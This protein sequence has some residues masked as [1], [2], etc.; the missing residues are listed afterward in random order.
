ME[1]NFCF[2]SVIKLLIA[3]AC[4]FLLGL[5]RKAHNHGLGILTLVLICVSSA[6]L[7]LLSS[8]MATKELFAP[9]GRG[10]PT[11][12][13]AGVISGIGFLGGG[14]IMKTGLNIRGLTSAAVIWT[15]ASLGL[16]VGAG[17]YIEVGVTLFLALLFLMSLEKLEYKWFPAAKSKTIHLCY[18]GDSINLKKIQETIEKHKL[19]IIDMNMSRVFSAKP[20]TFIHYTVKSPAGTIYTPLIDNLKN[21]G[22]LSE[23]SITD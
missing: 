14:A 12:I 23:F 13:A 20:L 18:E 3:V 22:T 15:S 19:I 1:I 10:D 7:S 16:A 21:L 2:E 5:E 6:L 11:R 4:G 8:Y 9:I 17:L